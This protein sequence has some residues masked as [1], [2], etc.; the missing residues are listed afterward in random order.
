M[1]PKSIL[2]L[3][4][5][6]IFIVISQLLILK[7]H[8]DY[9]FSDVDWGFLSIYKSQNPYNISQFIYNLTNNGT[10]GG[11]YTHQ[12][13]YIGLQNEFFGFN[14]E[15][16]QLTTHF[17]K[18]LAIIF[19]FPIFLAISDSMSVAF[20]ATI[21]FAFSYSA[22]GTM[23]T[24]VTSSDYSAI[25]SMGLFFLMYWYILR[26]KS[27]NWCSLLITFI[28]L[29]ITIFLSTERMYPIP[30]FVGL[31]EF[32]LIWNKRKL[33]E[34]TPHLS[35]DFLIRNA[36]ILLPVILVFFIRPFI[37]LDFFLRNGLELIHK[38]NL[39]DWNLILTP[40][41]ALGSIVTVQISSGFETVRIDNFFQYLEL[42]IIPL[43]ILLLLTLIICIG[44]FNRS[45]TILYKIIFL[46][47]ISVILLY[48]LSV[49]FVE[50]LI[51]SQSLTQALIGLYILIL[52]YISFKFWEKRREQIYLGLFVG[53]LFAFIYILLTWLGAATSEIFSGV[54]R[55]LTIPSIGINFFIATIIVIIFN[56]A[57]LKRIRYIIPALFLS[58]LLWRDII[59]IDNFFDFQLN[60]GFRLEDQVYMRMQL[61][62]YLSDL[63][64][65]HPSLF[66]FDFPQDNKNSYFY[67]NTIRGG[68]Q[69]WML[70]NEKINFNKYLVPAILWNQPQLLFLSVA[71]NEDGVHF[72]YEGKTY[73]TDN[74]Y[75]FRLRDKK[76]INIKEEILKDLSI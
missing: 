14:F 18:I 39:G 26:K 45:I 8:L 48:I 7:P 40:L 24:V 61:R 36:F 22:V 46:T 27:T 62:S 17:F 42:I 68:F 35:K 69:S 73:N 3:I 59:V 38:I 15:K 34:N 44:V 10:M 4:L 72:T 12:I 37:F 50:H 21:L 55:Y 11:V 1:K 66:Y 76:V 54:H 67:D 23:Y 20:I 60:N 47:I 58:F 49:H 57:S 56:K 70:W 28:L 32:F 53:P 16:Y 63:S 41:I 19:S 2:F 30:F 75:A 51:N 5:L 13:Y 6:T 43:L 65:E 74:F 29:V 52:A 25:F 71:K 33:S 9:G 64:K 31:T